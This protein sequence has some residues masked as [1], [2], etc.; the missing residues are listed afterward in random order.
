MIE[1]KT[2]L[3]L[4]NLGTPAAPT[5]EA[6][7]PYLR[8]FLTDGRV[9]DIPAP[10]RWML[11]NGVIAPFRSPKSAEAYAAIWTDEGSPLL[12]ISEALTKKVRAALDDDARAAGVPKVHVELAMR[13]AQPS[14]ERALDAMRA[15]G[16]ER[17]LVFP[18][19]PQYSS[20]AT[21]SSNERV[22][23]LVAREAAV[24]SLCF[25][26][27]F[28]DH[29]AFLD[30]FVAGARK[31]LEEARA[32]FTLFSFHGLPEAHVQAT[33]PT[34]AHCLKSSSCCDSIVDANRFCYRAQCYATA[35]GLARRLKLRDDQ[36]SVS[37]Q[38]RLGRAE[39]VKPYTDFVL[40]ELAAKGVKRLAVF[41]PAFVADCLETL[42]EIGIR[43][44][45]D[46]TGAGG[47]DLF[48]MPCPNAHDAF[49]SAVLT[50]AREACG[51]LP[52]PASLSAAAEEPSEVA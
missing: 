39:W 46:F 40:P 47:E 5:A 28:Y 11:V 13:Y 6:V 42:E 15:E 22:M 30:A 41:C 4:V 1:P 17:I 10:L 50:L 33:D 32:D 24:P 29:P 34:G 38:S 2:G 52:A 16:V 51:W 49:V 19:Y 27:H 9:I 26:P 48:L 36:W 12:T 37:F 18:L 3:L 44:K 7:R 35:R 31:E 43:A 14:L 8:E 21:G 23:K 25:V 20:A 45:E